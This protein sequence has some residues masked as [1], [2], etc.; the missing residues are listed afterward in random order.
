MCFERNIISWGSSA[1]WG[2]EQ[3]G[4]E[5]RGLIRLCFVG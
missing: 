5:M 1:K 2:N 4:E 3:I